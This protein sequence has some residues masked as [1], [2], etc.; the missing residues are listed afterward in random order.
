VKEE[1]FL[2]PTAFPHATIKG[3]V[4]GKIPTSHAT[5]DHFQA[6]I[7]PESMAEWH[8]GA[9]VVH[10]ILCTR[11]EAVPTYIIGRTPP[12]T[13]ARELKHTPWQLNILLRWPTIC[14]RSGFCSARCG[15]DMAEISEMSVEQRPAYVRELLW[16]RTYDHKHPFTLRCNRGSSIHKLGETMLPILRR[17]MLQELYCE[18]RLL[19][20]VPRHRPINRNMA[21]SYN[22]TVAGGR[23]CH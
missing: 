17:Q 18:C 2:S 5:K 20:P 19:H 15:S 11:N 13:I 23:R 9:T 4:S 10:R 3:R 8:R 12:G 6:N 22:R 1:T 7:I 21:R 14:A 16:P